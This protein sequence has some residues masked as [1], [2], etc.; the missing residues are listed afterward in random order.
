MHNLSEFIGGICPHLKETHVAF[1]C[2][3]IAKTD[4]KPKHEIYKKKIPVHSVLTFPE[5]VQP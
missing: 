4:F 2:A 1:S 3:C 5:S